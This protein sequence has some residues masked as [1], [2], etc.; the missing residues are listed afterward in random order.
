MNKRLLI[1]SS[2]SLFFIFISTVGVLVFLE[3]QQGKSE[4]LAFAKKHDK[5][6]CVREVIKGKRICIKPSC[7]LKNRFFFQTCMANAKPSVS[8]CK[9][10]PPIRNLFQFEAWK[11]KQCK[12][13]GRTD[14][15]C[16]HIWQKVRNSCKA[17]ENEFIKKRNNK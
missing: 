17:A 13:T 1:I 9:S 6:A 2:L 12:K 15:G 4:G 10:V 5:H 16:H 8:L 14:R 3:I 7:F 11:N